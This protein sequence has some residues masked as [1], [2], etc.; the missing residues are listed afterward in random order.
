MSASNISVQLYTVRDA[1]A[2]DIPG[3]LARLQSI[4]Y[5]NVELFGFL[6]HVETYE[7]ALSSTGISAPSAHALLLGKDLRS[8]FEAARRLGVSTLIDPDIAASRW[9]T[10]EDI[11][12][13]AAELNAISRQ[14]VDAGLTVGYHN[15]SWEVR[16]RFGSTT[17]L[18]IF[19]DSLD[20]A[21]SLEVDTFWVE[22]GGVSAID[23]LRVLGERV[24]FIH[25]KDGP[26]SENADDQVGLGKG[27]IDL[28]GILAAAPQALR[29]VELDGSRGDL[30]AELAD[31]FAFLESEAVAR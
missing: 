15:H 16:N 29:V 20:D 14:A 24:K 31:S 9:T 8:I 23:L 6:D 25:I 19:A 28:Q 22:V 27:S 21:V 18:E 12:Q 1:L 13:A 3:T 30:F 4:G 11:E 2:S 10:R 5:T 7:A 17:A 26:I